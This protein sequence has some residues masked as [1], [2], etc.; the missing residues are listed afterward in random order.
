MYVTKDDELILQNT[1]NKLDQLWDIPIYKIEINTDSFKTPKTI[2]D[3][4]IKQDSRKIEL[5]NKTATHTS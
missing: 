5:I 3:I 4:Y 1:R 2:A